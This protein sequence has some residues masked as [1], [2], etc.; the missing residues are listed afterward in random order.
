MGYRRGAYNVLV[1]IPNGKNHLEDLGVDGST[2]LKWTTRN[3]MRVM[4]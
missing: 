4:N 1:E 3:E 2:I